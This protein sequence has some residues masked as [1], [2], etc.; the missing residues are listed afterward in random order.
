MRRRRR[1]GQTPWQAWAEIVLCSGYPTQLLLGLLIQ[2][3]GIHPLQADGS[4]SGSFVF[5]LSLLDTVLLLTLIVWLMTTPRRAARA[6]IFFGER[7][8]G[9][10]SRR[11]VL[12]AAL[13]W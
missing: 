8:V 6:T 11:R 4:L 9:A 3:S 5:A 12:V 13:S 2:A 7:P 10:R 1:P